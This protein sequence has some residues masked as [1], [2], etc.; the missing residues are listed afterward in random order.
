MTI[1]DRDDTMYIPAWQGLTLRSFL[2]RPSGQV[3]PFPFGAPHRTSFHTA[4]S[5]IYHLFKKL[6]ESGRRKVLAPDYHMGNELR[7]LRAAG[8]QVELYPIGHDGRPDLDEVSRR[9][10]QG[11]DVLFTIHYAGWAQPIAELR[12]ICDQQGLILVEDCALALFSDIREQPLGSFGDYAVFCLYKTLPVLDGGL[13]VQNRDPFVELLH[14]PLQPIGR[15]FELGRAAELWME[16]RRSQAPHVGAVLSAAKRGIGAL[17]NRLKVERVPVGDV[18]F[19]ATQASFAMSPWSYHLLARLECAA[20]R[21]QR[22]KNFTMLAELL[23]ASGIAPWLDLKPGV[24]PLFYPLLVKDKP[25]AAATLRRRG[26]IATELWN[27]GDPLSACHEGA[28]ARFLRRHVLEL[29]IHQDIGEDQIRYLAQQVANLNIAL[30][31]QSEEPVIRAGAQNASVG[32]ST[33]RAVPVAV[34][35]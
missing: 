24:C 30:E 15:V 18:G 1:N 34:S 5:A 9:C 14:V 25:V 3:L 8:A 28:G 12:K 20:I 21:P 32:R 33:N 13:L 19:N 4:R 23:A 26:V 10:S 2:A 27:E 6:V 35:S 17:L 31:L 11:A 7:A 16:R 22:R 29:P